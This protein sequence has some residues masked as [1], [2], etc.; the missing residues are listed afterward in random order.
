MTDPRIKPLTPDE[1]APEVRPIFDAYL[2]E[3]GNIPNMFRTVALRPARADRAARARLEGGAR[4]RGLCGWS[5][6][7][8]ALSIRRPWAIPGLRPTAP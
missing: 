2:R 1:A 7:S 5:R 6:R 8:N 3:R 4:V